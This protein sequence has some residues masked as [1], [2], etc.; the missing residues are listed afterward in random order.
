MEIPKLARLRFAR[1]LRVRLAFSFVLFFTL[2]LAIVG[3]VFRATLESILNNQAQEILDEEWGSVKGYLSIERGNPIWFHDPLDP[4]EAFIVER[5]RRTYLL[6]DPKGEVREV[7]VRY[8]DIGI[9]SPAQ[10][11]AVVAN[12]LQTDNPTWKVKWT[13]QGEPFLLRQGIIYDDR[14]KPWFLSIGRS[15]VNSSQTL[16]RFTRNYSFTMPVMVLMA[17]LLGWFLAGRALRPVHDVARAAQRI[18]GANLS[19]R[20]PTREAGDELDHLILTFNR[21]MERLEESFQQTRQFSTDVSHELRTPITAIRGQLEVAL[22]TAKSLEDYRDAIVNSLQEV[23]RLSQLVR[24]MLLLSQ[25][26][27][28]QLVLQKT[29]LD[30][31]E[32]VRD[33]VDQFQIPAEE[34]KVLLDAELPPECFAELDRIQ[35][36]RLVSNLLSNALKYTP[37]GG[38]VRVQLSRQ[39]PAIELVVKDTGQGIPAADLPHI[40]DRFYRVQFT[41]QS[42]ETGLGLGLSFVA[43]IAKAHGGKIDVESTVGQGTRFIVSLPAGAEPPAAEVERVASAE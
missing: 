41:G 8:H 35:M 11:R 30:F 9:D 12:A 33:I 23:E 38:E 27:S 39:G 13:A 34:A 3:L 5:L 32:M 20:L 21:M 36:G 10:I 17:A 7:S 43:W 42:A 14:Q 25:S 22:F 19:L 31:A 26:E 29:R 15:L 24:A 16:D 4:E 28:G 6:V 18:S 40:F 2:L 37:A 1:R